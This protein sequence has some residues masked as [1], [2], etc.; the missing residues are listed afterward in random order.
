LLNFAEAQNEVS[1]PNDDIYAALRLIRQRAG[2]TPGTSATYGLAPGMTQAEMREAIRNERRVEL[3][4]EEHRFWDIRRWK[5][6]GALADNPLHG[7]KIVKNNIAKTLVFTR[8]EVLKPVF[9]EKKM[10]LFPISQGEIDRNI[11]LIQNPGW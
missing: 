9:D 5:I 2:I 11:N 4:F 6:A 10:Y 3:A 8:T 1:G 7:L